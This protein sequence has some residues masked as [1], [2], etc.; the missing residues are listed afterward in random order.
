MQLPHHVALVVSL[1]GFRSQLLSNRFFSSAIHLEDPRGKVQHGNLL[2]QSARAL[3]KRGVRRVLLDVVGAVRGRGKLDDKAVRV[4]VL[5]GLDGVV[6]AS[7]DGEHVRL[8]G[9]RVDAGLGKVEE[10][11]AGLEVLVRDDTAIWR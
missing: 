1:R 2:D 5:E 8:L 6:L 9:R 10:L 11:R 7:L 4:A 3:D